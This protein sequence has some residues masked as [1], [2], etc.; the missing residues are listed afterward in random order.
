[1]ARRFQQCEPAMTELSLADRLAAVFDALCIG[2]AHLAT[3]SPSDIGGLIR[4]HRQRVARVALVA[5]S[6]IDPAAFAG[7][8][9]DLLY[10]RPEAGML[11]GTAARALPN[12]ERTAIATLD[13]Y[14]AESWSDLAAERPDLT[15]LLSA[16]FSCASDVDHASGDAAEG[17]VAG[18]RFRAMGSGPVLVLTPLVLAPS[19]WEPLLPA[20]AER[21]RVVALAGPQLGML[22]LL[23]ERAALPDWRH[24]CA[25]AFDAL[26]V[27]PNDHVL[28]VGCGSGA[29]A[30]QFC[31]H[32]NGQNPL[33]A[34]DLSPYLVGEAR[35]AA[36]RAGA[37][38]RIRFEEGS[39]EALPFPENSFDAA[40]TVTVLEECNA[41]MALAE[42]VRVVKPGG[43]AAVIVRGVE[44]H[45]WWNMPLPP[46]IR[47]KISLPAASV[48]PGGVASA[49]LYDM[50]VAASMKPLRMY[51]YM[52]A[53]E[54]ADGPIVEY[55]E[56]HALSLL[57]ADERDVYRAAKAEAVSASTFFMTRG[58]HCFV[59]RMP[60]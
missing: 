46:E 43:R 10:I 39:A 28:D 38:G 25:G 19:Q 56:S 52:V 11:A 45:Q 58:H 13:G 30:I 49:A 24:M 12:L 32:T 8:G 31:Q 2:R 34:M 23:E 26:D 51:T 22:A 14:H 29:V 36:E 42:L 35:I 1:M 6:R 18:I 48:S 20:L 3:Q 9:T 4:N 59:G 54:R 17:E 41:A 5:P 55:P 21:F 60:G 47:Q 53:S 40:Y 37:A 57:A 16:H 27:K 33:T 15:N 50:A 7:L 44:L